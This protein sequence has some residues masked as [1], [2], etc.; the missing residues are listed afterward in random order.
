MLV[1]LLAQL[2]TTTC[3]T[4]PMRNQN[5]ITMGSGQQSDSGSGEALGT[6]LGQLIS[7]T[8]PNHIRSR[9]GKML[10]KGDCAGAEQYALQKG[11]LDLAQQV[12]NYCAR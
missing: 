7:G 3:T 9:I 10:A 1:F 12:K 6:A 2:A 4:D 8:N 11:E 5:C